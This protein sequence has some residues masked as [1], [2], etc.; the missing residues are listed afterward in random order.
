MKDIDAVVNIMSGSVLFNICFIDTHPQELMAGMNNKKNCN[1]KNI[2]EY[3]KA[4]VNEVAL[5]DI[6]LKAIFAPKPVIRIIINGKTICCRKAYKRKL[7][8]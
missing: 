3:T 1:N 5:E 7:Y 8:K 6:C 2:T 4:Y